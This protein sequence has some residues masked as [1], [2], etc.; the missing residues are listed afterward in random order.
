M[1][2][3]GGPQ[4]GKDLMGKTRTVKLPEGQINFAGTYGRSDGHVE[5]LSNV[6]FPSQF[7]TNWETDV[8]D[9]VCSHLMSING[10]RQRDDNMSGVST[11]T[12]R[13][14]WRGIPPDERQAERRRRLVEATLDLVEAK[15]LKAVT[16]RGV[17]AGAGLTSRH[18]YESF[19]DTNNLL[20]SVFEDL[21]KRG[22]TSA[23]EG[24]STTVNDLRSQIRAGVQA[25]INLMADDVRRGRFLLVHATAHPDLNRRRR[26]LIADAADLIARTA[27][28][29]YGISDEPPAL[30]AAS[31][32]SVGGVIELAT[33]YVEGDLTASVSELVEIATDIT[34]GAI[35]SIIE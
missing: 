20:I 16:V 13:R 35:G 33:A 4:V 31:R 8:V 24:I 1:D 10:R 17:C 22:I 19:T 23:A 27:M 26:Q 5:P 29:A 21:A 32:F 34:L 18:F 3:T 2:C 9:Y 15:G 11:S 7:R 28:Q 12:E 30:A 25:G 6:G 14:P